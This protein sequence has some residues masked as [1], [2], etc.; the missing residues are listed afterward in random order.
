LR[1]DVPAAGLEQ[2][3]KRA[4]AKV[5]QMS[6]SYWPVELAQWLSDKFGHKS[7]VMSCPTPVLPA[8]FK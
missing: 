4:G 8:L 5:I 6:R 3:T 1:I 7:D 2:Q